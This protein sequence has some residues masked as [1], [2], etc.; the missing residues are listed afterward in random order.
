[1]AND[2]GALRQLIDAILAARGADDEHPERIVLLAQGAIRLIFAGNLPEADRLLERIPAGLAHLGPAHQ[3][4]LLRA[5]GWRALSDGDPGAYRAF[6]RRSANSFRD[7]GDARNACVQQMNEAYAEMC[8][9]RMSAA[10]AGLTAVLPTAERL[11]LGTVTATARHNLGRV[12]GCLGKLEAGEALERQAIEAFAHQRDMRLRAVSFAYLAEILLMKGDLA[13]ALAAAEA[14][15]DG[16]PDRSPSRAITL[17]TLATVL[18]ADPTPENGA[19]AASAA[20]EARELLDAFGGVDEGE[21]LIRLAH[22]RA[23]V[24]VGAVDEARVA[25][26]E[27]A[28]RLHERAARITPEALRPGFLANV[29]EH[30]ATFALVD[31][32]SA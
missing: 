9:G 28:R 23:L 6:M 12:L 1:R 14:A 30:A 31:A 13:G 16:A 25:A 24:A 17:A 3:G 18:L 21:G 2:E 22:A 8:L 32:L 4:W 27:A 7:V 15:A 5:R 26:T 19:R 29:P 10:E 20:G 11:G